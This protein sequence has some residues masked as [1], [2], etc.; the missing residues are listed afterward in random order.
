M[1][2]DGMRWQE[3]DGNIPVQPILLTVPKSLELQ[4]TNELRR[5]LRPKSFDILPY[6]GTWE[7]RKDWWTRIWSTSK[8][9]SSRRIVVAATT[10]RIF[11]QLGVHRADSHQQAIESDG[12]R[13]WTYSP[14]D[15]CNAVPT[16]WLSVG[17]NRQTT[18]YGKD[19]LIFGCDE[20][21]FA[22]S[23]NKRYR[24]ILPLV[25]QSSLSVT[26]TAT[27]ITTSMKVR[28]NSMTYR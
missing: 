1:K 15:P 19:W 28:K 9:E 13:S 14:D 16:P 12:S 27:P 3:K 2:S 24:S 10:V 11:F 23:N 4:F 20:F 25:R 6:T 5:Y 18:V 21:H 7:K 8:H 17:S 26:M 22:R